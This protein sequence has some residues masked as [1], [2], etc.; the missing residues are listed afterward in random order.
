MS[1]LGKSAE[2]IESSFKSGDLTIAVFGMGKMGLPLAAVFADKGAQVVGM[3][4][5]ED[6][7]EKIN[8]GESHIDKELGLETLVRKNVSEGRLRATSD[9]V[10]AASKADVDVI[11]VPTLTDEKGSVQ[12]GPVEDVTKSIAEGLDEGDVVITEATMPPGTTE[13]LVPILGK[14]GLL[15]GEFGIGHAP[16]RTMTGT[17]VRDI[18]GQY[19]K[20]IGASDEDTL[21]VMKGIYRVVN[22]KG[23][24]EM[25][26]ITSAEAVKV[27]E[28]V[29]RDVNIGLANELALYCEEKGLDALEVFEAANTQPFCDIHDPGAGVGGHCIPVYPWFVINQT[30]KRNNRL[31]RTARDINDSMPYYIVDLTVRGLNKVGKSVKNSNILIMGLTF[32]GGVKEFM[33]TPAKPIIMELN[34]WDGNIFAYDPMC[35]KKDAERFGAKWKEE[36]D[37][38]DVMVFLTNHEEFEELKLD[39][40]K[41]S[42]RNNIIIDGRNIF[43]RKRVEKLGYIYRSVGYIGSF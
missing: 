13:S 18:T 39:K 4:I 34:K 19:P 28:G 30:E 9:A 14:S 33:K 11:L 2:E 12:L 27:F 17:A 40:I 23:V 1:V 10:M 31:L 24:I 3:D 42:L 5:D 43:D 32:R 35:D 20:I 26:E 36:F 25:S 22:E 15:L 37:N 16:E 41:N 7:V 8:E 6:V 38:I 21:K 29:Y